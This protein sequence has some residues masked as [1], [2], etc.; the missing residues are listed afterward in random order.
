MKITTSDVQHAISYLIEHINAD[1]GEQ[2]VAVMSKMK[3]FLEHIYVGLSGMSRSQV[4]SLRENQYCTSESY[5]LLSTIA[6]SMRDKARLE[7]VPAIQDIAATKS[8]ALKMPTIEG[9]IEASQFIIDNVKMAGDVLTELNKL[10]QAFSDA[11]TYAAQDN[12]GTRA[13]LTSKESDVLRAL[14]PQQTED[15]PRKKLVSYKATHGG[16]KEFKAQRD[17]KHQPEQDAK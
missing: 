16:V 9:L 10:F 14:L 2:I 3:S 6:S 1:T 5:V 13:L 7:R 15:T 12:T 8:R 11:K 17:R 4:R